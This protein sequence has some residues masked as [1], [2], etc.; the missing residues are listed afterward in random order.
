MNTNTTTYSTSDAFALA[1]VDDTLQIVTA[2][3]G[4]SVAAVHSAILGAWLPAMDCRDT[5]NSITTPADWQAAGV[6][7]ATA[8]TAMAAAA[9]PRF[10]ETH[11]AQI[12]AITEPP[13]GMSAWRVSGWMHVNGRLQDVDGWIVAPDHVAAYGHDADQ[14]A[15]AAGR[16]L[17]IGAAIADAWTNITARHHDQQ[18]TA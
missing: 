14:I 12:T 9:N 10:W 17:T 7:F 16:G 6:L 2:G 18:E 13:A 11:G 8:A 1:G 4:H 5:D 15:R 3:N